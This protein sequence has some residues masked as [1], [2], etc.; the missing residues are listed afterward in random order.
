MPTAEEFRTNFEG[1]A[2]PEELEKLRKFEEEEADGSYFSDG[3]ELTVDDKAG[4]KSWSENPEFL[5]ALMPFAQANGSGSFYALWA[6]G[7]KPS[8]M[9]VVVFGDEG[10][11]HVV[12]ENVRSLMQILTFDAEPSI[13]DEVTF[14]KDEDDHEPSDFADEYHEW[15]KRGF[16]LD[17]VE[18]AD[19]LV[20]NAQTKYGA[21]FK[22]WLDRFLKD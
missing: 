10:G 4:L 13:D 9:P 1:H 6:N 2:V 18:E 11:A 17:A 19:E 3:F 5:G 22:T 14:Y 8:Q 12:A 16:G 20:E 15:L 7:E 21:A